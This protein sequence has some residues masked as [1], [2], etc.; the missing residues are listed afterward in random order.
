MTN[1]IWRAEPRTMKGRAVRAGLS[2]AIAVA[3][4]AVLL[5]I[6]AATSAAP[7]RVRHEAATR[8]EA[9]RISMKLMSYAQAQKAAKLATF[10]NAVANQEVKTYLQETAYLEALAAANTMPAAW[11]A[12]ATCEEGGN[13]DP[14][15]GYF[16]IK[17]WNGFDGYPT[18]GSAPLSVQL[19]WESA[20]GISPPDASGQCHAY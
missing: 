17:E 2:L 12:T 13:D 11:Q 8:H 10:Y 15:Y 19:A 3:I 6:F 14:N 9:V 20:H 5:S 7:A 1:R 18:A 4:S 16:G